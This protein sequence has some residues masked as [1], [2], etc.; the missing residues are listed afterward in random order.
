MG[1]RHRAFV[2]ARVRP[3]G[4]E[5]GSPGVYRC[6][7]AFHHQWCY[8]M[9]AVRA[10]GRLAFMVKQRETAD[11]VR[12]E[13][14]G[15]DGLYGEQGLEPMCPERPCPLI[16]TLLCHAYVSSPDSPAYITADIRH[17]YNY[18]V[19]AETHPWEHGESLGAFIS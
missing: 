13:L 9:A 19:G 10:V 4:A 18:D 16:L 11:A 12:A 8:G 15:I 17:L 3:Y 5:K 7:A 6:V 1:H 14:R 2:I